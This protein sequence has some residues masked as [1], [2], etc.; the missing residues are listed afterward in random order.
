MTALKTV[1]IT[2]ANAG[3]GKDCARQLGMLSTTEKVYLGC[4]NPTK[5]AAA[6]AELEQA[7]GRDVFEIVMIDVMD[8][9]SV[10][11]AVEALPEPVEG[12]VMN[13]GGMGGASPNERTQ[14]GATNIFAVNVLGH[15]LLLD[16]LIGAGKLTK[17]A[18]YAGSEA[19]R[20]V[21]SMMMA[22]PS[23]KNS[24]VEEFASVIDGSYFSPKVDPMK[25]YGTI[26]YMAALWM[27]SMARKHPDI[28]FVTMSPG[29]TTGT[30]LAGKL[31]GF[32]RVLMEKIMMPMMG[33]LGFMHPLEVGA[34]R[35]VDA[36]NEEAYK[37]GVFYA[38]ASGMSGKTADQSTIFADIGDAQIQ[39]NANEAVHRFLAA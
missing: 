12:L 26:K 28:R 5:A 20:G 6:K 4:R 35:Y 2:G 14:A 7:T 10:R 33:F 17:V 16:E 8:L 3:L 36:L 21:K 1:L 31:S 18:M 15:S 11:A 30:E 23:L 22:R 39:D 19:A 34:K 9:D 32:Q 13:A 37:S 25:S 24:S 29:G 38:S 27:S